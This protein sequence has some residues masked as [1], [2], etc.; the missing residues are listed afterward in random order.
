MR[1][2]PRWVYERV[3]ICS[4]MVSSSPLQSQYEPDP[5]TPGVERGLVLL[6]AGTAA[7]TVA[8]IYFAQPLLPEMARS[9]G[10]SA[11]SVGWVPVLTQLGYALGLFLFIPLGD[12]VER[13]KLILALVLASALALSAAA[14]APSAAWLAAA[15][16]A[17]GI[18]AVVPHVAVPLA[19][20]LAAPGERGRV[21]GLIMSGV[22]AGI[23]L[24]RT[25]AGLVGGAFGW[26]M[27]YALA[28]AG[29]VVLALA[30]ARLLPHVPPER[31]VRYPELLTSLW[32]LVRREPEL[33]QASFI[34]A[35]GFGAF[36]VFW[37]TLAFFLETPPYHW[38]AEEAGLFGLVGLAG[39]LAAPV[40]GRVADRRGPRFTTGVALAVA[41]ASFAFFASVGTNLAGLVLGVV[42]LDVGV[43][44]A[45]VSNLARVHALDPGARSRR[46]TVYMVSYFAGGAL[47]TWLGVRA[48]VHLGWPGVCL[49]GAAFVVSAL[50]AWWRSGAPRVA[51][52]APPRSPAA[53]PPR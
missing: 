14:A 53:S 27:V 32:T 20:H 2:A 44:S 37:T 48:W 36:S 6:L 51:T 29:M 31:T 10:V 47:G 18:F 39:A 1:G 41:L 7:F 12:A 43:Q 19:A 4:K 28:A 40:V 35:M 9:L 42:L 17:V 52:A 15:S 23:L 38:G 16:L 24:A 22:L 8:N 26:R 21:I 25:V 5:G 49:A 3:I 33:R 30:L 50:L 13:R 11:G 34:G 45:H 46:N